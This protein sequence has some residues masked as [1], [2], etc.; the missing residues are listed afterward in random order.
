MNGLFQDVR[1]GCRA[2]AKNP[3][4][5]LVAI[6]TLALGIGANT[7]IFNVLDSALLRTIPVPHADELALLTDPEAHGH[8]YGSQFGECYL[9]AFWEFR[10]LH[11][12]ND[13]FSGVFAADSQLAKT[14]V[15]V[16]RGS[17]RQEE[18]V[19]VRLVSGDYFAT[20]GV[21]PILG[22][23]FGSETDQAPGTA[24]FAVASYSY[25]DSRFAR[26]PQIL[27]TKISIHRTAF[28][29]VAVAPPGFFGETVGESPDLWV[30]LT[31]QDAVYPGW[32]LM[33]AAMPG[34]FNQQMWPQVKCDR[35]D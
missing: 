7:A 23:T 9:L 3:A 28:E 31:M 24:P 27:G 32:D 16:S 20:L 22:R 8:A 2:L 14:Q 4:F 5:A 19:K 25:W 26:D 13:V 34:I 1:Y 15:I 30:P 33:L 10:Y 17:V 11:D 29:I 6:L 12:H 21:T 35:R 18:P